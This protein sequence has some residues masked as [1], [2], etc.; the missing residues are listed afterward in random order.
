M[1]ELEDVTLTFPDGRL[2]GPGELEEWLAA[3][4]AESDI[5]QDEKDLT[6]AVVQRIRA[7]SN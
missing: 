1:S 2:V 5:P 3:V 4:E 6:W 7:L